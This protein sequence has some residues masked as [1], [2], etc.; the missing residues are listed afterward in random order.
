MTIRGVFTEVEIFSLGPT[1]EFLG[2]LCPS[3]LEVG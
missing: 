1:C 3:L 2:L